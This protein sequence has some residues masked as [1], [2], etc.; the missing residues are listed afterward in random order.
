[1]T[2]AKYLRLSSEDA[3]IRQSGKLESNSI[4]NQRNLIQDFISRTQEF[5][6]A[7]VMEFCDDGW[8][9]KNFDRPA[10]RDMLEQVKQGKIQCIIVKDLSRFGRDYLTV[11]N[12]ISR[13][14][15][16][17]GVRFIAINDGFDSIRSA[18]I[19]SLETSF[20][21]LLYDLYSRDLSRKVQKAKRFRAQRGECFSAFVPLGYMKDPKQKNHLIIDP[22]A[23][24][25]VRRIFWMAG[26]GQSPSQ[27]ARILNHEGVPTRMQYKRR[28][29]CSRTDW[30]SIHKENFWVPE[31]VRLIL[32]DEQYIG[33]TVY[34]KH[35]RKAIGNS[36]LKKTA[37]SEW[38]VVPDT[39]E[40]IVSHEEFER[41]QNAI[42]GCAAP[43]SR[44]KH[45]RPLAGKVKC[46]ICGHV[47][48][49]Y[50]TKMVRYH[51]PTP[52]ATLAY[53][54]P[55]ERILE[56]DIMDIL[57][58]ELHVR[59]AAAVEMSRIWEAKQQQAKQGVKAT[60]KKLTALK[61]QRDQKNS[62]IKKLYEMYA[63]GEIDKTGYL[64]QKAAIVNQ[65][66][67][68][69]AQITKLETDLDNNAATGNSQNRFV[70]SFKQYAEVKELTR[71][72]VADVLDTLFVYP[73]RR[74]EIVWKYE[75]DIKKL[76]PT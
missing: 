25:I 43:D 48:E 9:G 34:G 74:F 18:D 28:T 66:D 59:A 1:M 72:I 23:A 41:A 15:P 2:I 22:E 46:G 52:R 11:G 63:L 58:E 40:S 65:R 29:D 44:K 30:C 33:K 16:F 56:S 8:S 68:L 12:Y 38:I 4:A 3:D 49:R 13:V 53:A 14:F 47:M 73:G 55:R 54:C 50:G 69:A 26:N 70:D 71:E 5:A 42:R 19:D 20:K 27:I 62:V 36:Q 17:M 67:N 37:R 24:K 60:L 75:D 6:G 10:V 76:L 51:C 31:E 35:K 61:E 21:E 7:D 57:L 64:E 45:Q 32:K 39:H